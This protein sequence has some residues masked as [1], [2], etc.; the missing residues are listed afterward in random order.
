MLSV[1]FA[2]RT[3]GGI[4][5]REETSIVAEDFGVVEVVVGRAVAKRNQVRRAPL[6]IVASVPL[7]GLPLPH[8]DPD[9]ESDD[10][11]AEQEG[12]GKHDRGGQHVLDRVHIVPRDGPRSR[13]A[14]MHAMHFLVE[15]AAL[16]QA[17]VQPVKEKIIEQDEKANL[18]EDD[19]PGW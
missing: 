14:V 4:P 11:T 2:Q 16:V 19:P 1:A 7:G 18:E 8:D 17:A 6:E 3:E 15:P 13:D 5:P 12:P 10:V 9:V